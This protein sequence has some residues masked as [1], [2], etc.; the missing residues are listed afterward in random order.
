[1]KEAV[2]VDLDDVVVDL[3]AKMYPVL[4]LVLERSV[5]PEEVTAY[6]GVLEAYGISRAQF[7]DI[8]YGESVLERAPL[9]AGAQRGLQRLADAGLDICL[10]TARGWHPEGERVTREWLERHE[11]PY[12]RLLVVPEGASKSSVY[13][14]L[15]HRYLGMFD[16]HAAHLDDAMQ[17][18]LVACPVL[19]DQPW[20]RYRTDFVPGRNRFDHLAAAVAARSL[21]AGVTRPGPEPTGEPNHA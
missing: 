14:H 15:S 10:C 17:S 21:D 13:R 5:D 11:L 9:A 3:K 16:D 8:L 18:G 6:D 4:N 2:I 12:S 19:I 20:N 7:L 1:M